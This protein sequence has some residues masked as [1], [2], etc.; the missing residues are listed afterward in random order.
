[1]NLNQID[2]LSV[3]HHHHHHHDSLSQIP[4]LVDTENHISSLVFNETPTSSSSL[5]YSFNR[6]KRL[7]SN[8]QLNEHNH[9]S[10]NLNLEHLSS[11]EFDE[12]IDLY[13]FEN[14]STSHIKYLELNT[15]SNSSRTINDQSFLNSSCLLGVNTPSN[16]SPLLLAHQMIK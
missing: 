4:K 12:P 3:D 7:N 6:S 5:N 1:M 15:D 13:S 8:Y 16:S 14:A 9:E 10:I 2:I 11:T